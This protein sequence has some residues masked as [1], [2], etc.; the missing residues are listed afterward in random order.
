MAVEPFDLTRAVRDHDFVDKV[1]PDREKIF[2][3]IQCGTCTASCPTSFAMDYNPRQMMRMLQLGLYEE[4][5]H[6]S[7]FWYCTT[8]YS[9]T[10]RCPRGISI[11]E[12]WQ[13]LKRMSTAQGVEK[14]TDSARFYQSFMDGVRETGRMHE[15]FTMARWFLRTN[16]FKVFGF[17]SMGLAM[18]RK[19]KM[20]LTP[21]HKIKGVKQVQAM[22]DKAR[23]IEARKEA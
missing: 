2:T 3:C 12:T 14:K 23:E 10:V 5:L 13:A 4:I 11:T 19:G 9:C 20:P 6:S 8:C 1:A 15:T 22:F 17:A 21:P 7:T 16:P 18:L